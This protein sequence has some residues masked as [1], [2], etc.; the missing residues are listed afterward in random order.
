[1]K[2]N[3][4]LR[5]ILLRGAPSSGK[6]T[7]AR[8]EVSKDP[9]NWMRINNDQLREMFNNSVYSPDYE[10]IVR[11][12]RN[13]LIREGLRS[14]KNLIID[15]V[16]ASKRG[17]D[18]VVE[19]AKSLNIDVQ[20]IEKHFYLPLPELLER[21]AKR[22]GVARVPDDIVIKFFKELGADQ[23][24]YYKPKVEVFSKTDK[25]AER[26][27][28]PMKQDETLPRAVVFDND[29][30][31]SLIH[32]NRSPYDARTAD[33]DIPHAHAIECMKLYNKAG[34]KIIF[35]SG[36]EEKDRAPTERF[37]QKHFP[38]VKYE[39]HMRP[40]G[41]FRK[42]VVIK[43]EIFNNHIKDKYFV[44]GWF[45]DRLQVVEWLYNNGFPVFRVGNPTSAF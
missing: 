29:G 39:L 30:T 15:N 28:S 42:D 11:N 18:D 21:N 10:K 41:D 36:R 2:P 17:W 45:D 23:F 7:W 22:E 24:K 40:T 14:G 6:S 43:E 12:T 27:V 33:L 3:K 19:I 4:Q 9:L 31:I 35:V 1:M 13:Y 25:C 44:A 34:Y 8:S 38:E 5:I 37:Y 20:V 26:N 32:S 16:N